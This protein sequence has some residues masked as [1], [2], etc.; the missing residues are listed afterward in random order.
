LYLIIYITT[1]VLSTGV[2][3]SVACQILFRWLFFFNQF[4]ERGNMW[5]NQLSDWERHELASLVANG[6]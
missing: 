2:T 1:G 4:N 6:L 3:S 5:D